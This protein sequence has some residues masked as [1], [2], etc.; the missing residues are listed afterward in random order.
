MSLDE[1]IERIDAFLSLKASEQIPYFGYFLMTYQ[2]KVSFVAKDIE[3][4]F[5]QSNLPAYSNITAYLSKERQAKRLLKNKEG[6]Y[7]LS[8]ITT[9]QI[10]AKIGEV[11]VKTPSANL[12]PLELL[13]GTRS[14][15]QNT[16]KQAVLCYDYQMY[17]ACLVMV[18]RLIE[19]LIIEL[20]ERH[21]IKER[22]QD[23]KGNY[24]FCADLID[25]LLTEKKIWAI[26]RNSKNALPEIKAKGDQSAHNRRFNARKSDVDSIQSGLRIVIEELVHLIDYEQW[27]KDRKTA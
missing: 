3:A 19:T 8:K 1:Y 13:E 7:T 14:Y 20:F 27:N 15:L 10:A 2:G 24:M 21:G 23:A 17:D 9:D 22:I 26:G 12:F 18:R 11:K 4:C 6:G 5:S 16:A 25:N